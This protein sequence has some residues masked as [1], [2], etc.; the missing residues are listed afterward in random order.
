[1]SRLPDNF[2]ETDEFRNYFNIIEDTSYPVFLTGFAGT[3]KSTFLQYYLEN[4]DIK[5]VILAPT[6]VAAVNVG[7]QTIHSFFRFP[8]RYLPRSHVKKLTMWRFAN[9]L[10]AI[11][12]DEIS[13]VRADM[14]D[15]IDQFLRLN[16]EVD[17]PFGGV[18]LVMI[19]DVNQLSP[20]VEHDLTPIFTRAYRSPYF[21]DAKVF[22]EVNL[23]NLS[24]THIFRQKDPTFVRIL[25]NVREGKLTNEDRHNLNKRVNVKLEG[26]YIT[27]TTTNSDANAINVT[28]LAELK[29]EER[30]YKAEIE[31]TF[32]EKAFPTERIL[33]LKVGAQVMM[34][35]NGQ[36]Y[37]NGTICVVKELRE[38]SVIVT[39][40]EDE[41]DSFDVLVSPVT[42]EC[43]EYD[44]EDDENITH[45]EVGKFT[46]LPLKLA[47]A[48]TIHKSQGLTFDKVR[49][50]LGRGSFAHGQTYVA[51]S[52]CR[53][54]EGISLSRAITSRDIIFD[55]KSIME[56]EWTNL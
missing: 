38:K 28:K 48:I 10:K 21:F 22:N 29:T 20:V 54:L 37:C 14:M 15:N 47:W 8:P 41:D 46:Q 33:K 42:F 12:I 24:L 56:K 55:S 17:K 31:G 25:N 19:G 40:T 18:K 11:V 35:R 9:K 2:I 36:G 44:V 27:L 13:M 16:M 7:G 43:I 23:I 50:S 26:E 30:I 6:G 5:P 32:S 52:R 1:M 39:I 45:K 4:T 34:L 49:I 53:S 3:G 51:L